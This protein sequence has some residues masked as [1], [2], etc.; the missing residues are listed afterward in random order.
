MKKKKRKMKSARPHPAKVARNGKESCAE[1]EWVVAM[2]EEEGTARTE[3]SEIGSKIM[4][5]FRFRVESRHRLCLLLGW[6]LP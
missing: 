5:T 1:G 6:S 2:R 3:P 4:S